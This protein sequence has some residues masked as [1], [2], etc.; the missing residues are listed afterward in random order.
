M[1][2]ST[3]ISIEIRDNKFL[4]MI[5]CTTIISLRASNSCLRAKHIN[6]LIQGLLIPSFIHSF[7]RSSLIEHLTYTGM[8]QRA[9]EKSTESIGW[10]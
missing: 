7:I 4:K 2:G 5:L 3:D 10:T 8:V 6:K 9:G 1:L